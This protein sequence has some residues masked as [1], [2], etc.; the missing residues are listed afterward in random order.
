MRWFVIHIIKTIENII[1][2]V[3]IHNIFTTWLQILENDVFFSEP[4]P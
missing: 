2:F 3:R 1:K 4:S